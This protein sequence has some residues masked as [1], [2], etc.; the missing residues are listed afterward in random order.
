MVVSRGWGRGKEMGA[1]RVVDRA[2]LHPAPKVL[3]VQIT[4]SLESLVTILL[5]RGQGH[6][7]K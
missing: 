2:V 5:G 7:R 3:K 6:Q 1:V 4:W